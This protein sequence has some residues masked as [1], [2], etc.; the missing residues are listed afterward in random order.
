[1]KRRWL[2]L[3]CTLLV[4]LLAG[5]VLHPAVHWRLVGWYRG[6]AFYRGRPTSW[7]PTARLDRR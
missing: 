4:L 6:E 1:M 7:L 2:L 5:S 3:T